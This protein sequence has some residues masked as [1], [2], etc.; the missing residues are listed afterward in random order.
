MLSV[1]DDLFVSRVFACLDADG[2]GSIEWAEFIEAMSALEKGNRIQKT[3]F[4]FRVYDVNGDATISKVEMREFFEHSLMAKVDETIR[5]LSD[6]FI[7]K[8]FSEMDT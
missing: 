8:I 2:S 1:E 4:L 5:E 7:S 3:E 6:F